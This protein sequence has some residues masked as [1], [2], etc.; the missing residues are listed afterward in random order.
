MSPKDE[1]EYWIASLIEPGKTY[2]LEESNETYHG[3]DAFALMFGWGDHQWL[4]DELH[5]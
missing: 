5:K 1:M 2:Y 3:A 4:W